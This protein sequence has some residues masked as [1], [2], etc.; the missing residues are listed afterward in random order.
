MPTFR[1]RHDDR[2]FLLQAERRH[3]FGFRL[4]HGCLLD[5]AALMVEAV[6]FSRDA[7]RLGRIVFQQ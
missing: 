6:E 1:R 3:R 4:R 7:A 5:H 2:A